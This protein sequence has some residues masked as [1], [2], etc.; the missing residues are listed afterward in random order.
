CLSVM[1]ETICAHEA[2]RTA[3]DVNRTE[4]DSYHLF[5]NLAMP[6][7]TEHNGHS[8]RLLPGDIVLMGG[9]EHK[10]RSPTGCQ[11]VLIKCPA[12][13]MHPWLPDPQSIAGRRISADSKWGRVLA[14]MV[15]QLT[16]DLAV[17]PPLPHR[18][19]V[20]QLGAVLALYAGES[21]ARAQTDMLKK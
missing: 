5:A 21:A 19:L 3:V 8:E 11:A 16:P 18:V 17:A 7:V 13:W 4:E 6:W 15:S 12:S 20:D 10:L 9:G 14:P 1:T 2:H